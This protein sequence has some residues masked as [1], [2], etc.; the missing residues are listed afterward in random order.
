MRRETAD[1]LSLIGQYA[2]PSAE[3]TGKRIAADFRSRRVEKGLTRKDMADKSGVALANITRFEQKG[4]VSLKNLIELATA[5][6]YLSEL[7]NVFSEPKFSTME[8][9]DQIRKN[10]GKKKAVKKRK[11]EMK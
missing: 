4:L 11:P 1:I 10:T 2:L 6:G 5:L 3:D 7:K 8:E 9:L